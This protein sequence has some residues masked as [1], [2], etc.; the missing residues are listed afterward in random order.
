MKNQ[1]QAAPTDLNFFSGIV[2]EVKKVSW[3]TR[4]ETIRLT[5]IVIV[6][7]FIVGIYIGALDLGFTKILELLTKTR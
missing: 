1:P 3:P 7:T 6:M 2:D 4:T 5:M